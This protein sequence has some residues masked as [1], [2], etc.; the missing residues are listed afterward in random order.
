MN[1]IKLF[2][3]CKCNFL[4]TRVYATLNCNLYYYIQSLHNKFSLVCR[5]FTLRSVCVADKIIRLSV[6]QCFC[7]PVRSKGEERKWVEKEKDRSWRGT[8]RGNESKASQMQREKS[9]E[10]EGRSKSKGHTKVHCKIGA[11]G[12]R[13]LRYRASLVVNPPCSSFPLSP[14]P[15]SCRRSSSSLFYEG[16]RAQKLIVG[17]HLPYDRR[18]IV[19]QA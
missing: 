13:N 12:T 16:A 8:E 7:T 3:Q 19:S 1:I 6:Y 9:R 11:C 10:G 14:Y 18:P 15:F 5:G 17:A 2:L 4:W